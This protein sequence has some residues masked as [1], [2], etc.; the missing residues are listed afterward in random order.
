MFVPHILRIYLAK[1]DLDLIRFWR[2]S[3][4]GYCYGNAKKVFGPYTLWV[5]PRLN[6]CIDFH[7]TFKMFLTQEDLVLIW[8]GEISSCHGDVLN[9]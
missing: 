5:F 9:F 6:P 1:E 2:I 4:N 3:G 7:H 8:F